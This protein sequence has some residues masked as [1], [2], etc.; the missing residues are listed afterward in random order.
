MTAK[1]APKFYVVWVGR[2]TGIF[3][4]QEGDDIWQRG[5]GPFGP[6]ISAE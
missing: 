5:L 4:T 1:K 3:T 6:H 2:Q